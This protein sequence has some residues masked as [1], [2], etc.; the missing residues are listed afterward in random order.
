MWLT[1]RLVPDHKTIADFR[2]NNGK[3]IRLVGARFVDLCRQMGLLATAS[4]AI[5]GRIRSVGEHNGPHLEVLPCL[6]PQSL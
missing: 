2:K 4:V 3:G 1:G 5:D 6:G